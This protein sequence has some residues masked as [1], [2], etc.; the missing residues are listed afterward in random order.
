MERRGEERCYVDAEAVVA[1][2]SLM[3]PPTQVC[4]VALVREWYRDEDEK[5]EKRNGEWLTEGV[6]D[7]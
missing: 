7:L 6:C 2:S 3:P 1:R 5:D 4:D